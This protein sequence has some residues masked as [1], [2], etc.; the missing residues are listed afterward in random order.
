MPEV[1]NT[2]AAP[3]DLAARIETIE[4]AYEALLAYAAQG[5]SGPEAGGPGSTIRGHIERAATALYGL[6]ATLERE[7]GS[8]KQPREAYREFCAAVAQDAAKSLAAMRLALALPAISSQTV[9]NLNALIHLRALLT[10]LF[11]I[12]GILQ[13]SSVR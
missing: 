9:D 8:G 13:A 11:F 10:D 12:D 3:G 5:A 2:G 6:A 7:N 4:A 1:Q